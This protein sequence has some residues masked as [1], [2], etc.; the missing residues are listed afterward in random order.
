MVLFVPHGVDEEE[1]KTR[2]KESYDMIY[3]YLLSC[4][5]KELSNNQS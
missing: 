1:D 2:K 3:E 4:G 5:V